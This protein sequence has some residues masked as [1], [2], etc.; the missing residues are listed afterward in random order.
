[1][2]PNPAEGLPLM[3]GLVASI[4]ARRAL[5]TGPAE[6]RSRRSTKSM[7]SLLAA[8]TSG[9]PRSSSKR[10]G[11]DPKSLSSNGVGSC[12]WSTTSRVSALEETIACAS[13][14]AEMSPIRLAVLAKT[15]RA[16]SSIEMLLQIA[17]PCCPSASSGFTTAAPVARSIIAILP[18]TSSHPSDEAIPRYR[19]P[20]AVETAG[21]D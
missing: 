18:R 13:G 10:V 6:R 3:V 11:D 17:A 1:M 12:Q 9:V 5:Q 8:A 16:P 20:S 7:P 14:S 4:T 2:L 19:R 21:L 15:S